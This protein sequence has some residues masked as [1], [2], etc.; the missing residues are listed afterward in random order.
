MVK[1]K[2]S[3]LKSDPRRGFATTSVP[4]KEVQKEEVQKID[5]LA[6]DQFTSAVPELELEPVTQEADKFDEAASETQALQDVVDQIMPLVDKESQRRLKSIDANQRLAKTLNTVWIGRRYD[7]IVQKYALAYPMEE[8]EQTR[9]PASER[10]ES[11]IDL[12]LD[13]RPTPLLQTLIGTTVL[14][15]SERK[16]LEMVMITA[17]VLQG[18]QFTQEQVEA[19]LVH[20]PSLDVEDAVAWLVTQLPQEQVRQL[21]LNAQDPT[22][23]LR[24]LRGNWLDPSIAPMD[25]TYP[26][27]HSAYT[28]TRTERGNLRRDLVQEKMVRRTTTDDIPSETL[29]E[30]VQDTDAF[31]MEIRQQ[32]DADVPQMNV[33]EHPVEAHTA[34]RLLQLRIHQEKRRREKITGKAMDDQLMQEVQHEATVQKLD[35]LH[36]RAQE[37]MDQSA[38]QP[39]FSPKIAMQQFKAATAQFQ[40][41]NG[42]REKKRKEARAALR[43]RR[44]EIVGLENGAM[45]ESDIFGGMLDEQAAPETNDDDRQVTL[46][47]MTAIQGGQSPRTLLADA[48][49][50][51]DP[52][53]T[54]RICA[55][56]GGSIKRSFLEVRWDIGDFYNQQRM[57]V[58]D[59]FELTG[60]GCSTQSLANDMI[61]TVALNCYGRDRQV[62]RLLPACFRTLWDELEQRRAAEKDKFL[63]DKIAR[64]QTLLQRRKEAGSLAQEPVRN[65]NFVSAPSKDSETTCVQTASREALLEMH[66]KLVSSVKYQ[67]ML[68]ERKRLPIYASRQT[69]LDVIAN[70]QVVVL[71]GETGCGKSTQLPAYLLENALEHGEHCSIYVTEPRRISAI[72]LAERVAEEMGES[73]SSVGKAKSLLGYSIRLEN[74]VGPNARLVYATTGIVLRMLESNALSNITHVIV[75]EVHERSI[76]SDFLLIVLKTLLAQRPS[77]KVIL[78]SATLDAER[79]SE[80]FGGCPTIAVPGRTFAV[81]AYYLEDALE[82]TDYTLDPHSPYVRRNLDRTNRVKVV[83]ADSD[84]DDED[85]RGTSIAEGE[86]KY[87]AKTVKTLSILN[88]Y[89]INYELIAQLISTLSSNPAFKDKMRAVLVFLPGLGEIRQMEKAIWGYPTLGNAID[90]HILHSN[91]PPEKQSLAFKAPPPGTRKIVLA[92]NIAETGITIPDITCVIDTGKHRQMEYDE[93]RKISK[94]KEMFIARSNAK[95]RRGRAGRV[96]EGICFHLF[97]KMRNDELFDAQQTPEMLRLSLQELALMLKVMQVKVGNSIEDALSQA[98]DPPQPINVQRAISSLVQVQA[99][100]PNEDITPLGRILSRMPLDVHLGK[101]LLVAAHFRCLDPALSI[102]AM[103]NNRSPFMR[104][105]NDKFNQ[106]NTI[107][108]VDDSDFLTMAKVFSMWRQAVRRD[109]GTRF[110][111]AYHV[112][113]DIMYQIE[114]LRQQYLGYLADA[115]FVQ[116]EHGVRRSLS[117]KKG[118]HGAVQIV[119][120]PLTSNKYGECS[121]AI[122]LALVITLYPKLASTENAQQRF[123]TLSNNQEVWIHPSSANFGRSPSTVQHFM[124][125][126]SILHSTKPYAWETAFIPDTMVLLAVGDAEYKHTSRSMYLDHT[127]IRIA[128]PDARS[129]VT[130]RI[131]RGRLQRIVTDSYRNP[132]KTFTPEENWFFC[133]ILQFLGASEEMARTGKNEP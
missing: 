4:K 68:Q 113:Q 16:T 126:N 111:S 28:F 103:L 2:K 54:F 1:K 122:T 112:S 89:A 106:S 19:A 32:L 38:I 15:S 78:M 107:F 52:H 74:R 96:Q 109:H 56:P 99:L 79:I 84:S 59:L 100:T 124:L 10:A 51:I 65:A 48:L 102:A 120:V 77:L 63:R 5:E 35:Q 87:S 22:T 21:P 104:L 13:P 133:L 98:L 73:G 116:L 57:I 17:T 123:R 31:I 47:A 39:T 117:R 76:E 88:E 45:E 131:L 80:Y 27:P 69:I 108:R 44:E 55:L 14:P 125:Y 129:L 85:K 71:S 128:T 40:Q 12:L 18:L 70:N 43:Q 121:Q 26:P 93:K 20:A 132:G 114:E 53:A 9:A 3:Q 23:V 30:L 72:S 34:A 50:A 11:T 94:L 97:T 95:Q 29:H 6:P 36:A 46:R 130:L 91:V 58:L 25:Q 24:R 75:D 67:D 33:V 118:K 115:G 86:K 61:A 7:Q 42:E 119:D 90:L 83:A 110:C 8:A 49:R 66:N 41:E 37:M 81:D 101:F 60:E 82:M 64:M 127:K 62:Q 105:P 92:T